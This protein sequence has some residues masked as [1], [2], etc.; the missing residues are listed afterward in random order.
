MEAL[1]LE[2]SPPRPAIP[3]FVRVV[4]ALVFVAVAGLKGA[5]LLGESMGLPWVGGAL[6]VLLA[7][8]ILRWFARR[9]EVPEHVPPLVLGPTQLQ[10]PLSAVSARKVEVPFEAL[11]L[12]FLGRG[13]L[14][15]LILGANGRLFVFPRAAF[16]NPDL[17][18]VF[19]EN[20]ETKLEQRPGGLKQLERLRR[21]SHDMLAFHQVRPRV[22][23]ALL[24][25]IVAIYQVQLM[26]GAHGFDATD[27]LV[28][29][30]AN[31]PALVREGQWWRLFSANFLHGNGWHL[32]MNGIALLSLGSVVERILGMSRFLVVYLLS[33]VAGAVASTLFSPG[34]PSVGASGAIF[35]LLGAFAYLSLRY[36][37]DLPPGIRQSRQWWAMVLG[38][39]FVISLIPIVDHWA[40][41]GGFAVGAL[42]SWAS[43]PSQERLRV[44]PR[45]T[46]GLFAAAFA[47]VAAFIVAGVMAV[48]YRGEPPATDRI[49]AEIQKRK[50][51]EDPDALNYEAWRTVVDP[52]ASE[53]ELADAVSW[54]QQ[55]VER[56]PTRSDFI[57]TLATARYR[58][59]RFAESVAIEVRALEATDEDLA[60]WLRLALWI[61]SRL[62]STGDPRAFRGSQLHRFLD[63][64]LQ[65]SGRW[66]DAS[67]VPDA[68]SA[69]REAGRLVVRAA[70]PPAED[71]G[72]F[73]G[74]HRGT[75]RRGLVEV[76]LS[77]ESDQAAVSWSELGSRLPDGEPL[78]LRVLGARRL[79][80]RTVFGFI[81]HD[82]EVDRLPAAA[83][84]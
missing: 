36:G 38:I 78:E 29:I 19:V 8:L 32:F 21:R 66:T 6:G 28:R 62:S 65:V 22:T 12:L 47:C 25:L 52:D 27:E 10:L 72:V 7:G 30:G 20:L 35:G 59:G 31:V 82:P 57:D 4:G 2:L 50:P 69:T 24:I 60:G 39:N 18:P 56:A 61:E 41:F 23:W 5:E 64:H 71:L 46:P 11:D 58:Q 49:L 81:P 42:A 44:A 53:T 84:D 40:H 33:A 43:F 80:G 74:L 16:R 45:G 26:V 51:P 13:P 14:G 83:V 55:A 17:V 37:R 68:L 9:F 48:V 63:A 77:A 67:S 3:A 76:R 79:Q 70:A 34:F 75:E 54:A 1:R 73:V 15:R